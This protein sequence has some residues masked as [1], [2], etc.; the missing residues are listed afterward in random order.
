VDDRRGGFP[1]FAILFIADVEILVGLARGQF[2]H[3]SALCLIL[4][5][6]LECRLSQHPY[7]KSAMYDWIDSR[8]GDSS[9]V[10]PYL[11]F[12]QAHPS[13]YAISDPIVVVRRTCEPSMS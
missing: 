4:D 10:Y 13:A 2:G 6:D 9:L 7:I 1:S 5:Q 8:N 3:T 12:A 11:R